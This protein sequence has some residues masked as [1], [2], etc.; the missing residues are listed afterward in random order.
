MELWDIYD[1]ERKKTGK[2]MVRGQAFEAGANHLVIHVCI[3]NAKNEMLI[4]QRQSFKQGWPNLW[5]VSL[6]GSAL[7]GE[8]S[9]EAAQ[10]EAFEE[11]GLRLDLE[12]VKPQVC[13]TFEHGFD[14]FYLVEQEVC[15]EELKLQQSEVQAVRWASREEVLHLLETKEF[16]PFCRSFIQWLFDCRRC[17][18]CLEK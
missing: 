18:G 15:L 3:F 14:D 10:R 5:D 1:D 11:L 9:R 12:G 7:A 2:T 16:L 17:D 13:V 8:N 4:Q 6:G